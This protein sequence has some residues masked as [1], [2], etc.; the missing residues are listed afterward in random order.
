MMKSEICDFGTNC[1]K[2][3]HVNDLSLE[4]CAF[5]V[6]KSPPALKTVIIGRAPYPK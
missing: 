3:V 5:L 4:I 1:S 2:S 6:V